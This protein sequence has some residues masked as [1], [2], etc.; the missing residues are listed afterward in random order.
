AERGD[1]DAA[2]VVGDA[3]HVLILVAAVG[4]REIGLDREQ[5][6]HADRYADSEHRT[7]AVVILHDRDAG[8]GERADADA[9]GA[10]RAR[11]RDERDRHEAHAELLHASTSSD[12][13]DGRPSI[14][15]GGTAFRLEPIP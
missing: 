10:G 11:E 4:L 3:A 9:G 6:N 7:L 8:A 13:R 15:D 2:A 5:R 12:R 1:V 14:A